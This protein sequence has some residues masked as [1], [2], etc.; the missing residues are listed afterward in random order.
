MP[1]TNLGHVQDGRFSAGGKL[2]VSTGTWF[3]FRQYLVCPAARLGWLQVQQGVIRTGGRHPQPRT[4]DVVL[5]KEF[6][7]ISPKSGDAVLNHLARL[8][9][10]D[11]LNPQNWLIE[12]QT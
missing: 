8:I 5:K 9:D 6:H 10:I 3:S 11:R 1:N 7:T 12:R 4:L 2:S